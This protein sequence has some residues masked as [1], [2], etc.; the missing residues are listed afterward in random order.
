MRRKRDGVNVMKN[1]LLPPNQFA[2]ADCGGTLMDC[3][4]LCFG[5]VT[6]EQYGSHEGN[7]LF[8]MKTSAPPGTCIAGSSRIADQSTADALMKVAFGVSSVYF[9]CQK[10]TGKAPMPPQYLKMPTRL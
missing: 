5:I 4:T 7:I 6:R 8:F 2:N 1:S 9:F 3:A 10:C